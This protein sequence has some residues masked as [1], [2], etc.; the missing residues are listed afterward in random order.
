MRSFT[1]AKY[2]ARIVAARCRCRF[3]M[4][5]VSVSI[6]ASTSSVC[7]CVRNSASWAFSRSIVRPVVSIPACRSWIETFAPTI[8]PS[9]PSLCTASW[10]RVRGTFST[11]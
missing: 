2:A 10:T 9:A 6:W 11:R 3:S 1:V 8:V 4:R 5:P 7:G